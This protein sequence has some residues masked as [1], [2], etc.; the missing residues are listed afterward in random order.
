MSPKR[1]VGPT[2]CRRVSGQEPSFHAARS[3]QVSQHG[4]VFEPTS[5][6]ARR[7]VL[8][9]GTGKRGVGFAFCVGAGS[10]KS[11]PFPA[12]GQGVRGWLS[13]RSLCASRGLVPRLGRQEAQADRQRPPPQHGWGPLTVPREEPEQEGQDHAAGHHQLRRA[14]GSGI[15]R[16][17]RRRDR[18]EVHVHDDA[19]VVVCPRS[20][21]QDADHRQ[22]LERPCVR[23]RGCAE[24]GVEDL[25]LAPEPGQRWDAGQAEK[26]DRET[27][28]RYRVRSAP[29][30][31]G[32]R[33]S[34]R[35]SR[36]LR[37]MKIPNAPNV[38]SA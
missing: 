10:P 35:G 14:C 29:G 15:E 33:P 27:E 22:E 28:R 37:A 9:E 5:P 1:R 2:K 12:R 3:G 26:A 23:T 4:F 34:R 16:T 24:R 20:R 17:D 11:E 13:S 25:K 7:R 6:L 30:R 36:V 32:P 21:V 38:M 8:L 31:S 18:P 19:Q